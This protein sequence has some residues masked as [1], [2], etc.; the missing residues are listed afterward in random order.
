[1]TDSVPT[2]IDL[3]TRSEFLAG[4]FAGLTGFVVIFFVPRPEQGSRLEWGLILTAAVF[5]AVSL[6]QRS[7]LGLPGGLVALALGGWLARSPNGTARTPFGWTLIAIGSIAVVWRGELPEIGWVLAISPA[8]IVMI[9][10]TLRAWA[11]RLPQELLG[12]MIAIS[13]FGIWVTVPET[14]GARALL[15]AS[16][17][18][19]LATFRPVGAKLASAGAFALAGLL[20]WIVATGGEAR[21][22]SIIGGWACV[23]ALAILPHYSPPPTRLVARRRTVTV[24]VHALLVFV[25]SR[26]IGIWESS[27]L[28]IVAVVTVGLGVYVA[29]GVLPMAK[30]DQSE[31][32][33]RHVP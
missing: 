20:V 30:T 18:M 33:Q 2:V 5:I 27:G 31:L 26:V 13:A 28:A 4:A 9:G 1:M 15:G 32:L 12:I 19:A 3:L 24:L 29:L 11:T 16:I 17:P 14:E 21:P 6:T 7:D 10:A 22:A 8:V 25:A 23:G